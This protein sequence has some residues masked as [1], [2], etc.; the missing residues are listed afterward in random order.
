M[1][2][3]L[4]L[5][6]FPPA[7]D[8]FTG[9]PSKSIHGFA[10]G[11][12]ACGAK[13]TI[14]CERPKASSIV[15]KYG[16]K[17]ECFANPKESLT[18]SIPNSLKNFLIEKITTQDIVILNGLFFPSVYSI[19]QILKQQKKYYIIS[20]RVAYH[21][22]IFQKNPYLKWFYWF[23]LEKRLLKQAQA[24]QLQ[25]KRQ[26]Q[27][28]HNL[29]VK[30]PIVEVPNGFSP[31]DVISLQ[32]LE[33]RTESIPQLF[34]FGRIDAHQKALDLLLQAFARI[35][36]HLEAKLTIQGP[37][38]G[39][40][41]KLIKMAQK[42]NIANK[43]TFLEAEYHRSPSEIMANYDI[44]CLP[45]RF[46][47]FANS[48]LEAML[49]GRVLLVSQDDGVTPHVQASGCGVAVE[50]EVSAIETGLKQLLSCRSQWQKMGLQGREYVLKN[51]HWQQIS[52]HALADYQKLLYELNS[53][54]KMKKVKG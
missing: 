48:A 28:L 13:V 37:D 50:P 42:L 29:G 18:F 2:I 14:L 41:E 31:R 43:V 7:G 53:S 30:T 21:P 36:Q 11:L 19:S 27:W 51:L 6:H 1:N 8:K 38:D 49:A 35:N 39:D 33:W 46:E 22:F 17:I 45:S 40:Q 52:T 26:A 5:K 44:F 10:S 9:G 3:Y 25:D 47:G 16:Y 4:Y 23:L 12:T 15:T 24:L 54:E 20:P 32:S 34:Y